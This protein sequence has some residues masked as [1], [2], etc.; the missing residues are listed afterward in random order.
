MADEK[1]VDEAV[2]FPE[3]TIEGFTFKPWT[4]GKL[5]DVNPSLEAIFERLESKGVRLES[6]L[7][8]FNEIKEIYFAAAPQL[9]KI[10]ALTLDK[11]EEEIKG[12]P[13]TTVLKLIFA[14]WQQNSDNLKNVLSLFV[15]PELEETVK[16]S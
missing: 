2:L 12:L 9:L 16:E 3:I 1:K 15:R 10:V 5:L 14:I 4:F 11:E 8:G 7:I 6:A 13:L